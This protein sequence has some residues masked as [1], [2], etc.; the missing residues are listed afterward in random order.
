MPTLFILGKIPSRWKLLIHSN[1]EFKNW[2]KINHK[3]NRLLDSEISIYTVSIVTHENSS[4]KLL[5]M[6]NSLV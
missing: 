2:E 1:S 4:W 6:L 5:W 3:L